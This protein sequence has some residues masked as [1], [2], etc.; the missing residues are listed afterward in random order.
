MLFS[1]FV[2]MSGHEIEIILSR[3]LA[4][5]L[6]IPIFIVDPAGNLIFYNE[7]AEKILGKRFEDTGA[8]PVEEW[9]TM[10]KPEDEAGNPLSAE[11]LPL[12]KSLKELKPAQKNFWIR[13]LKGK[14]YYLSVTSFPIVGR[15]KRYVGAMAIFWENK[16]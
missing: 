9:S 6:S 15:P 8:I 14:R 7:P 13:S 16:K 4:D 3:Q 2:P 10:F 11:E 12:V 1:Y 5:S